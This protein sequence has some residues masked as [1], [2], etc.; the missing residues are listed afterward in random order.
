[1]Q[2]P[3][4]AHEAFARILAIDHAVDA[5]EIGHALALAGARRA[6]LARVGLRVLTR[7]GVAGCEDRKSGAR[8]SILPWLAGL[9]FRIAPHGGEEAHRA[10]GVVAGAC[11][12]A[13]ADAV[14]LEFLRAREAGERDLG[15]GERERA[16]F[17]IAPADR[18]TTRLT[19]ATWRAWSSRMAA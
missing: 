4:A 8:G 15:S 11:G 19:S 12:D 5:G 7:S 3:A 13:D 6:E 17:R 9:Q 16:H 18:S 2:E 1:M 14:G 10:V